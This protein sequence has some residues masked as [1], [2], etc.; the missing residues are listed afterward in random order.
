MVDGRVPA[1]RLEQPDRDRDDQRDQGRATGQHQR[2]GQAGGQQRADALV[3][4]RGEPRLPCSTRPSQVRYWAR[5]CWCAE[6]LPSAAAALPP[7]ASQ[8]QPEHDQR[9]QQDHGD[10]PAAPGGPGTPSRICP[11][12]RYSVVPIS[13]VIVRALFCGPMSRPLIGLDQRRGVR[14]DRPPAAAR[15]GS[16]AS[17]TWRESNWLRRPGLQRLGDQGVIGGVVV[18]AGVVRRAALEKRVTC[19]QVVGRVGPASPVRQLP[20]AGSR[21]TERGICRTSR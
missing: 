15:P 2:P 9:H 8:D 14:L 19:R 11:L 5:N 1:H 21:R 6:P 16:P 20:G 17:C 18:E 10:R 12:A 7:G 13:G 3:Q 4:P